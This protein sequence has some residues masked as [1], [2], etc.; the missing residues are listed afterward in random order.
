MSDQPQKPLD[1]R[2]DAEIGGVKHGFTSL[3]EICAAQQAELVD[4]AQAETEADLLGEPVK[5]GAKGG[6]PKGAINRVT[7]LQAEQVLRTGQSPLAFLASVWRNPSYSIE[8]RVAAATAALPYC[9]R[10]QPVAIDLT[11]GHGLAL[12]IDLSG[13]TDDPPTGSGDSAAAPI[14]E[15]MV[16]NEQ[17]Q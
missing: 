4:Q 16:S 7:R 12:T 5:Q 10:K 8:R 2:A 15:A 17:N 3:V 1:G 13:F 6:R 11:A 14:I 9:H